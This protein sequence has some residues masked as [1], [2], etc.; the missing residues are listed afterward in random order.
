MR[1]AYIPFIWST[2]NRREVV[3][4]QGDDNGDKGRDRCK[5]H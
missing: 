5:K 4:E 1:Y 3:I 2:D